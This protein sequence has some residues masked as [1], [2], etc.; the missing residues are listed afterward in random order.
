MA[1]SAWRNKVSASSLS[2]G[3]SVTPTLA[4]TCNSLPRIEYGAEITPSTRFRAARNS[5]TSLT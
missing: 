2:T 5:D 3:N 4:Y 1:W